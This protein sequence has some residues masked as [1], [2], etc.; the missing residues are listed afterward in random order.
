MTQRFNVSENARVE[1]RG[2]RDRVEVVGWDDA[3]TV[4]VDCPARQEGN[5]IVVENARRVKVRAPRAASVSI[6][7]CEADVSVRDIAGRVE[8]ANVEGDVALN[9]LTGE[10][11]VR[12]L[13]GD[14]SARE[15]ASIKGEG[16]WD[17][18]VSMRGVNELEADTVDGDV[19][20][21]A[22][23]GDL[24][25]AQVDGDLIVSG[26]RGAV[27]ALEVEGDAVIS[28]D[29]IAVVQLRADGD[30]VLNLPADANAELRLDA[31]RGEL[32]VRAEIKSA[33]RDENHLRGTLGSGGPK[34]QVE[35]TRGD[36]IL[37]A[38]A[39]YSEYAEYAAYA[40][41]ANYAQMGQRIAEQVRESVRQSL[42][43]SGIRGY[44]RHRHFGF[45]FG[46]HRH[47]H[48]FE[49]GETRKEE[50]PH[51]PAAGTPER[52]AIL[53][54][55]ARGELGVDEAIKKLTGEK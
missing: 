37:R 35:S 27:E 1:I 31:P 30:V 5:T 14:L 11:L 23:D 48:D 38:G 36:V 22:M 2:C 28:I 13:D 43:E 39:A 33:E 50:K 12:E 16:T 29:A 52:Q 51:G 18:D 20:I 4:S 3:Q 26:I 41:Y 54:S 15:I 17:G 10:T 21:R 7:D 24:E 19:S 25:I 46:G 44:G 49:P 55:I 40:D 34:V 9:N 45:R 6:A 53:D 42:D 8:L 32:A 47:K